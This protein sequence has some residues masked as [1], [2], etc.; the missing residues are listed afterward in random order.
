MRRQC[1]RSVIRMIIFTILSAA[2]RDRLNSVRRQEPHAL[3]PAKKKFILMEDFKHYGE[4]YSIDYHFPLHDRE[5]A[6]H[7]PVLHGNVEEMT[8]GSGISL[9]QSDVQVLEP[10]ETSSCH[11]SPLYMLVVLEGHVVISHYGQQ[12]SI[13]AGT[14]Y[15]SRLS[16]HHAMMVRHLAGHKLRTL[17]LGVYPGEAWQSSLLKS[18]L[19]EWQFNN[20]PPMTWQIPDYLLA[21]LARAQH[22]SATGVARQLILEGLIMQLLGHGLSQQEIINRP[23]EFAQR[24]EHQRLENIRKLLEQ[25]PEKE[26]TLNGLAQQAAMSPSSLRSKFRLAYG[27]TIFDFLRDCRLALAHR[28]LLEGHSVQQAAWMSGYQHATNFST[29]FRRRYGIPPVDIRRTR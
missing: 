27:C 10:Y 19:R 4:R 12:Y 26:Y 14:T 8:L 21:G 5:T 13:G 15:V 22:G 23:S 16:S 24:C 2:V 9:T 6:L 25:A 11:E 20:A 28:Y 18:L 7:V 29:A 1:C 17:S 3:V